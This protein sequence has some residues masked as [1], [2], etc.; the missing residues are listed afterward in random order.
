LF[1]SSFNGG[2]FCIS[3][4]VWNEENDLRMLNA[5]VVLQPDLTAKVKSPIWEQIAKEAMPNTFTAQNCKMRYRV[6]V[7]FESQSNFWP[8]TFISNVLQIAECVS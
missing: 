1:E 4:G 3:A 6:Y 7:I 5:V 2:S 8:N